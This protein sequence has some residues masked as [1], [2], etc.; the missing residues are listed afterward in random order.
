MARGRGSPQPCGFISMREKRYGLA[1]VGAG[2]GALCL[3]CLLAA[4][5]PE[6]LAA[7]GR[8]G[9]TPPFLVSPAP[10]RAKLDQLFARARALIQLKDYPGA[11]RLYEQVLRAEPNSF[12][13][14][15]N[16]GVAEAQ[17]GQYPE[18]ARAYQRALRFQ[19][20][21]FPLL[22]NLGLC[23]FK[24]GDFKSAAKPLGDALALQPDNFQSRSLLAMSYYSRK[25]FSSASKEF[26]KLIAAHPD[27][28][29]IQY[30]LAE[31]YL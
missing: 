27:N 16:L 30:L 13:A 15:S 25:E 22:L 17:M 19:P 7:A 10:P 14:L 1:F 5:A 4:S 12:E 9:F 31:S 23:Y 26:E 2:W 3:G 24:S 28:S 8:G 20:K 21:S 29:T 18:A 11:A 6:C